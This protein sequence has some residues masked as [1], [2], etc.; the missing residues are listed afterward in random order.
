[1]AERILIAMS[2]GVDS[3][4]AAYLL[5]RQGYDCAGATMRL[6]DDW[7]GNGCCTVEDAR[8]AADRIGITHYT[9][10]CYREF[11]Q[12]VVDPFRDAYLRGDT[13]NPC[14]RCNRYLK[15]G[16]LLE[17]A[18]ELGFDAVATGHYARIRWTPSTCRWAVRKGREAGRDQSYFLSTLDQDQLAHARFP[19]GDLSKAEV[20]RIAEEQGFASARK[21]DSQDICFVPDG[22][23]GAFLE[24]YTKTAFPSG[25][26]LDQEGRVL[27]RHAGAVR[28]TLGQRKGLG[29]SFTERL[30]VCGKS[31]ADNTVTLGPESA[32]Y[33]RVLIGADWVWGAAAGLDG[34]TRVT[35]KARS[36]HREQEAVAEPLDG[37]RVRVVFDAPQ[38]AVTPG[39]GVVLYQ[40][41]AVLGGGTI[42]GTE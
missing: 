30:Y 10:S 23:Y 37:G 21:R 6:W 28:Y 8:Q 20:R 22:D 2:G 17:K 34:P 15:F 27:G 35:V 38:R 3:S 1:M 29:V 40:G 31:M 26:I 14:I 19:L 11:A 12:Q 42:V 5:T 4:V 36:R 32:L 33:S 16:V 18:R 41:D 39:Q 7:S 25:E 13:P 24:Y 9:F